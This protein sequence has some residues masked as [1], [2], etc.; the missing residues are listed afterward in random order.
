[1]V[2]LVGLSSK[3]NF[4]ERGYY[5]ALD[6][7]VLV[8]SNRYNV[9]QFV[10]QNAILLMSGPNF[11]S[12]RSASKRFQ[13]SGIPSVTFW[14]TPEKKTEVSF[15][16]FISYFEDSHISPGY[17]NLSVTLPIQLREFGK[18]LPRNSVL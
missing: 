10:P 9:M 2:K 18:V 7:F 14:S 6:V 13:D 4:P 15:H 3:G 17:D 1:M 5:F 12:G 8:R 11:N 16:W